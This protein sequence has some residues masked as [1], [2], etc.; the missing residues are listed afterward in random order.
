MYLLQESFLMISVSPRARKSA[1]G[2]G[3]SPRKDFAKLCPDAYIVAVGGTGM[4]AP[5]RVLSSPEQQ[6]G[7]WQLRLH[8]MLDDKHGGSQGYH[9]L[10][11]LGI[12]PHYGSS[13]PSWSPDVLTFTLP[14]FTNLYR[15]YE[16]GVLGLEPDDLLYLAERLEVILKM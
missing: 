2:R 8:Q 10:S 13:L 12:L 16:I 1:I 5:Y 14:D 11:Y 15:A 6:N 9:R 7:E 3:G 4:V